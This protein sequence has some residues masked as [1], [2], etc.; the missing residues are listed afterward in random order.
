MPNSIHTKFAIPIYLVFITAFTQMSFGGGRIVSWGSQPIADEFKTD[1]KDISAGFLHSLALTTSGVVVAWGD[2]QFNQTII[3]PTCKTNVA[4]ISAGGFHN[5]ALTKSGQVMAWGNNN[6][7]QSLIPWYMTK[8]YKSVSAGMFHSM[9]LHKSGFVVCWGYS[10]FGQT[11][12]PLGLV[13]A[14]AISAGGMHSVALRKNGTIVSWGDNSFGQL[15]TPSRHEDDSDDDS[16]DESEID[17]VTAI[18]AGYFHTLALNEDGRV[19][20]WGDNTYGQCNVPDAALEGVISIAA[21]QSHSMAIKAD[22]TLIT[23]GGGSG[24]PGEVEEAP[25]MQSLHLTDISAGGYHSLG[26]IPSSMDDNQN[27]IPDWWEIQYGLIDS[28]GIDSDSDEDGFSDMDEYYSDTNPTDNTSH[29]TV[30]ISNGNE[31]N[32]CEVEFGPMSIERFYTLEY[33]SDLAKDDW[34]SVSGYERMQK[35]SSSSTTRKMSVSSSDTSASDG[36]PECRIYRVSVI[37]PE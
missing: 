34:Q 12:A 26:L 10:E 15:D 2:N 23:W 31:D 30:S 7:G 18:S 24:V 6:D 22:G 36:Q 4:Q 5:L 9:A 32:T 17:D 27:G 33:S 11:Y 37:N 1:M 28:Q 14:V 29:F 13:D 21:G 25:S 35:N 8:S 16:S 20:A 19:Y 3:P